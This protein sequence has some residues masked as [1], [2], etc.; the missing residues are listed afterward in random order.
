LKKVAGVKTVEVSLNKGLATVTLTPGNSVS[1]SQLWEVIHKNGYTPKA[2][3]V[4][5]RGDLATVAGKLQLGV[6]GTKET[7]M[8]TPDPRNASAYTDAP[9]RLGQNVIIQG[10]MVPGKDF[11]APVPLQVSQ[12]K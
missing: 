3:T 7:L 5:V 2:T 12:V 4:S 9:K 1:V 10:V 11:K 8:L 6:S